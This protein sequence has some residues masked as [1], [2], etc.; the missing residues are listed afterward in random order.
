MCGITGFLRSATA[1]PWLAEKMTATV[2]AQACAIA[3][4]GPDDEGSWVDAQCGIALGHR[5]LSIVD[6]SPAGHQPMSSHDGR[7]VIVLN[8]EIYNYRELRVM[9]EREA[10]DGMRLAGW[11]GHSDTEVLLEVFSRW[12]VTEALKRV[13]GMF[14]MAIWDR[15]ERRLALARDRIGEKPLYYGFV[16]GALV[17][18]SELK[19]LAAHPGWRGDIDREALASYLRFAY[20]PH[21]RSIYRGIR[22]LLPGTT[23]TFG[24]QEISQQTLPEPLS[25]W[26]ATEAIASAKRDPFKGDEKDAVEELERLLRLSIRD[27]MLADVPLGALLSG[28]VDSSTVVALMQAQSTQPVRTFT[29][30]FHEQGYNE[31]EHA[32]AVA[33]HLGTDHTELYVTPRQALDVIPRLPALYDEPFADSSQIPTFLVAELAR[34]HVTVSLSGDA[35]DELFAGYNR[36][37][38]GRRVWNRIASVP[39]GVRG[40]AAAALRAPAPQTWDRVL[41]PFTMLLPEKSRVRLPG[42]KLHKLSRTIGAQSAEAFYLRLVSQIAEP[43]T[44]AVEPGE[45]PTMLSSPDAWPALDD[46]TERMMY[47]DLVSYLPDDILAKVDRAAMGVS[48]ETR[49]PLLDHRVVEFAWRLPLSMKVRNGRGKHVLRQVLYRHVP[50]A[51]IDRPKMGFGVPIDAWLRGPLREW[52]EALLDPTRMAQEGY[53]RPDPV[54]QKWNEHLSGQRNWSYWLWTVLMFQAWLAAQ[55]GGGPVALVT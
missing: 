8:G 21:A 31:A 3:H 13:V 17:F 16:A 54:R 24:Q 34:R 23:V 51:L 22:K 49:V 2:L 39:R 36:Y 5:R 41:S 10:A 27:Q 32:K 40:A 46:F 43:E 19:A 28:G 1:A 47:L 50:Q 20:V 25:Y 45:S 33:Q 53:M 55:S 30:G 29:I 4:R 14:A 26:S 38:V 6:L 42:D 35:G 52:A 11:R 44:V 7:Y 12:G 48:L 9:V 15:Q 37:F 18:G